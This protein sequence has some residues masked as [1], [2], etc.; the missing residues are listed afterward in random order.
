MHIHRIK[1]ENWRGVKSSEIS[2]KA[3]VTII[4][5]PNE[6]GKTT[7]IEALR[8]LVSTLD[9]S[10][11]ASVKAIKPVDEDVGSFIE[12]DIESGDYR[13]VYAKQFN[14]NKQ[15]SLH[16]SKPKNEQL[17]GREAHE[18]VVE[19]LNETMDLALWETLLVD[20]GKEIAQANI[21][22]SAG[23]SKSLDEAAGT[24]G[25]GVDDT[26]LIV[27]VAA[28]YAEFFTPTGQKKNIQTDAEKKLQEALAAAEEAKAFMSGI[29]QDLED[30]ELKQKE[31]QRL[32]DGE[33][34]LVANVQKHQQAWERVESLQGEVG[35]KQI[36]V[37]NAREARDNIAET[38]NRRSELILEVESGNQL[39]K[40][41]KAK[42]A[43]INDEVERLKT[44][45]NKKNKSLGEQRGRYSTLKADVAL[46]A[47]DHEHFLEIEQ[48]NALQKDDNQLVE[49][50]KKQAS[51]N[52]IMAVKKVD[53]QALR[54]LRDADRNLA[55]LKGQRENAATSLNVLASKD[56]EL[57]VN[58]VALKLG[59]T[60]SH[61]MDAASKTVLDIPGVVQ[62]TIDPPA[63]AEEL[64]E[65]FIQATTN[66]DQLLQ[67]LGVDSYV[68]AAEDNASRNS[69]ERDL[70]DLKERENRVLD[71]RS[72][73]EFDQIF[74]DLKT[75]CDE[76]RNSRPPTPKLPASL[77]DAKQRLQA[78]ILEQGEAERA[79]NET[80]SKLDSLRELEGVK[81]AALYEQQ[82]VFTEISATIKERVKRL[83]SDREKVSDE[84][85]EDKRRELEGRAKAIEDE[86][87]RLHTELAQASPE[88]TKDRYNN[89][90]QVLERAKTEFTKTKE[91][92]AVLEDRLKQAQANGKYETLDVAQREVQ[93]REA[94]VNRI[95]KRAAAVRLL[96][97]T[98]TEHRDKT[99]KAYVLPLKKRIEMLGEIVFGAGFEVDIGEDW[100]INS[101]TL[102][103]VTIPFD[104][105]SVG[106]KEQIGIITRLAVAQ[107]VSDQGGV[108]LVID[109]ALGFSDP[110][111]LESMGAA[112][113]RAGQDSQIL[114]LT[115]SPG[116]FTHVGN[117]HLITI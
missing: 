72:K 44:E 71:G 21:K 10:G 2:L 88:A 15:T 3:G 113:A 106:A 57:L 85:L 64:H 14:K 1:I 12:A 79:V 7:L 102:N 74:K 60:E 101:R 53:D 66:F 20:Q 117:A 30:L 67:D 23:L 68:R 94:A 81:Q 76:Y 75:R 37:N 108:P 112:I 5:G 80:Q 92:I 115:C 49:L 50:T 95:Q 47:K 4:E 98:L 87:K 6:A 69:A 116:R 90:R 40:A 19:I 91:R 86:F 107:I 29:D 35:R 93:E 97:S 31:A 63:T 55:I 54:K 25:G 100:S 83:K 51:A 11:A 39:V 52:A 105:L 41:K 103:D 89:A 77:D 56:L 22:D 59:R 78:L 62:L 16:I 109:D 73:A 114:L 61:Q 48:L 65:Q 46:A 17:T 26:G 8:L 70:K 82:Q 18:R 36:E 38:S 42:I 111:R 33:P 28:E 104:S 45:I 9:S 24:T 58:D 96:Y 13:F 110:S 34:E 84:K 43:P 27:A 99:R 32:Y